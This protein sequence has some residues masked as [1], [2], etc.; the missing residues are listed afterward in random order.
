LRVGLGAEVG[1][2]EEGSGDVVRDPDDAGVVVAQD[3]IAV[4]VA[5]EVGGAL[6][7]P[8]EVGL[9]LELGAAQER[10]VGHVP[11]DDLA[12]ADVPPGHVGLSVKVKVGGEVLA[13]FEG[14][15]VRH[16]RLHGWVGQLDTSQTIDGSSER[17]RSGRWAAGLAERPV[18]GLQ[19]HFLPRVPVIMPRKRER[20]QQA[21]REM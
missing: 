7:L 20:G 19:R 12:R 10:A 14:F 17:D 18:S 2:G 3:D 8:V 13:A 16:G 5:V 6:D 9:G 4:D 21:A 11:R 15:K 1:V